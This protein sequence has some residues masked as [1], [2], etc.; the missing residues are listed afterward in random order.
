MMKR[1]VAAMLVAAVLVAPGAGAQAPSPGAGPVI[2][3][4]TSKGTI[5]FETYPDEAPKTVAHIL[6]LV[7]RGFYNGQRFHR[8]VP[9][10]VIQVGDPLSRDMSKESLWGNHPRANSGKPIG[11]AEFSKRRTHVRGAV[12]MAHGG[13]P[14]QADSQFYI[15]LAP[16]PRLDGDYVVFGRVIAGADV[17]PKIQK[18]DL[19]KKLYVKAGTGN[20]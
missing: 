10:F 5:E 4:E 13:D 20:E 14:T 9:N 16:Q 19:V 15:T 2:V 18:T 12:G 11:V 1:I 6:A 3:M 7:K 8:V 17:P